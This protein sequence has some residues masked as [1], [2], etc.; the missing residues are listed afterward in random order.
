MLLINHSCL[1]L[2]LLFVL[3]VKL[4]LLC[5][6]YLFKYNVFGSALYFIQIISSLHP[7]RA[8]ML[9]KRVSRYNDRPLT[10]LPMSAMMTNQIIP[11]HKVGQVRV[12]GEVSVHLKK[13]H[14]QKTTKHHQCKI[15]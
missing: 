5:H 11:I 3:Q 15:G 2:H 10:H 4:M 13:C 14:H 8:S 1:L 9:L 6:C 7:S 12:H